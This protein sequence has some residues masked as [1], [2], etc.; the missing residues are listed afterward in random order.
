MVNFLNPQEFADY[1]LL[2]YK[3]GDGYIMGSIGQDP[4]K[5]SP[6]SWWFTQY[7]GEQRK[8]VLYWR[9]NAPHVFDCQGME[10]GFETEKRGVMT[11]V[12]ARNNY[13]DYCATKG[14]GKIP[15]RYRVPGATVF[16]HNGS[17]ISHVG[18]LVK[19]VDA[20][21]P[22]GDWYVIEARGVMYGVR[23]YKLSARNWNR[24]GLM[25]KRFNYT[26]VLAQYHGAEAEETTTTVGTLGSRTLR[27][28]SK[29]ADV[30]TMQ[31]IL[32]EL[33]YKLPEYG[34][35]GDFGDETEAAVK[36]FQTASYDLEVDGIYGELTHATL[37]EALDDAEETDE[38]T[39]AEETEQVV[40]VTSAGRWR[41]RK[42]PSTD[43][44]TLTVVP[45]GIE[46]PYISTADTGWYQVEANGTT[47]YISNKC[48][49]IK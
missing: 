45:Y 13:A 22:D 35:D 5:W 32:L 28:G 1:C 23:M 19:P 21:N 17:Y 42:G 6:G 12:R 9:E 10:D 48:A 29:G 3:E 37:M 47:G 8:K 38:D 39:V 44:D 11:N 27:N 33:G 36:A 43:Y 30:T 4:R 49:K 14:T 34:A 7:S 41:I 2:H 31:T 20:N 24:W 40:K 15:A 18:F 26:A 46:L 16:R 25:D